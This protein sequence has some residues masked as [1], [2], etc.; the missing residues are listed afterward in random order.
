MRRR[1]P[2]MP[3]SLP[4]DARRRL[5]SGTWPERWRQAL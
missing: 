2:E 1:Q 4:Q 3:L 5:V